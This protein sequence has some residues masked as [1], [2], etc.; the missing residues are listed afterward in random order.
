MDRDAGEPSST[1]EEVA[2]T[3]RVEDRMIAGV[4]GGLADY[5]GTGATWVRIAFVVLALAGG[6][7]VFIYL[8]C[9]LMVPGRDG[10]R[11]IG[12]NVSG[13]VQA[14]GTLLGIG[15]LALVAAL[16]LSN[17]GS[18][19]PPSLLWALALA[20]VG[21]VLL[22]D[23][24][25]PH[26]MARTPVA[27]RPRAGRLRLRPFSALTLLTLATLLMVLGA[28][29]LLTNLSII[30]MTVG[31]FPA[32]AL[33]IVGAGLIV[34]T[35]WGRSRILVLVGLLLVPIVAISSVIDVPLRGAVST[36]YRY[37]TDPVALDDR[38]EFLAASTTFDLSRV[39]F[40]AGTTDL[41]IQLGTGVV[42]VVVPRGI[43][44]DVSAHSDAGRLGVFNRFQEGVDLTVEDIF[45]AKKA[46]GSTL[47]LDVVAALGSIS[48][49]RG[50]SDQR[51]ERRTENDERDRRGK[52][53]RRDGKGNRR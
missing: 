33:V 15:V 38:Y 31:S 44:V 21:V 2:L 40:P 18:F 30:D 6:L 19:S 51:N 52:E 50:Y 9:W 35:R 22:R 42:D 16:L 41:S 5:A 13:G 34:G 48:I 39:D 20:A 12:A 28:L 37:V 17:T 53:R 29:G 45:P 3:R 10:R 23:D 36:S 4:A 32:L 14:I 47:K 49:R 27:D 25:P 8:L 1:S 11:L 24:E 43:T 46:Q 26:P 7:G